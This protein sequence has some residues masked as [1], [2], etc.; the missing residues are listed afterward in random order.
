MSTPRTRTGRYLALPGLTAQGY[1]PHAM[2]AEPSVWTEKNCYIDV[3]IELLH[4]LKLEPAALMGF[5][6]AVDFEGDHWTFF[7]PPHPELQ[8][9]YGLDVQELNV[10]R[11]LAEHALE[12]LRGGRLLSTEADAFWL[13]DTAGTDY[14]RQHTK[15]T[16]V[17]AGIDLD[18]QCARYFH[19]AGFFRVEGE[20]FRRLFGLGAPPGSQGNAGPPQVSL[21]PTGGGLGAARP[22]GRS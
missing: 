12:H 9:L 21:T 22:W 11:P 10:W 7:K 3:W 5:T 19:N 18:A 4:A 16:I 2:H 1:T 8:R 14:R 15:T 20:D 6:L 17:L 13:P